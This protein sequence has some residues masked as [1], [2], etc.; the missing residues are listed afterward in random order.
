MNIRFKLNISCGNVHIRYKQ[1]LQCEIE[2]EMENEI[3]RMIE[4]IERK[5]LFVQRCFYKLQFI[6]VICTKLGLP[7]ITYSMNFVT[8]KALIHN[9]KLFS[10]TPH[11]KP[12]LL[13]KN[14]KTTVSCE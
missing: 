9:I 7:L 12:Y 6:H 8:K 14:Q 3:Q 13:K 1:T 10:I 11:N 5:L 4:A 2:M